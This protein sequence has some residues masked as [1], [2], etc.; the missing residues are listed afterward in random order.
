[1]KMETLKKLPA[2]AKVATV[3]AVGY[4][5]VFQV[6]TVW[7]TAE[8]LWQ[9]V[10]SGNIGSSVIELLAVSLAIA[11]L[12]IWMLSSYLS[13]LAYHTTKKKAYAFLLAYLLL[14][15][16]TAPVSFLAQKAAYAR[17]QNQM[18]EMSDEQRQQVF[19]HPVR[20]PQ[21][22]YAKRDLTFPV[23]PTLLLLAIWFMCKA[24]GIQLTNKPTEATR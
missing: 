13:G 6:P 14:V 10:R 11:H 19:Q 5:A 7:M 17:W 1:M 9:G 16:I 12:G 18:M 8:W 20:R 4:V 24:E 23:G 2:W 3:L 22:A 21:V 15:T